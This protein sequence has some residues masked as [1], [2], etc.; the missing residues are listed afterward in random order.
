[1]LVFSHFVVPDVVPGLVPI[2]GMLRKANVA[3]WPKYHGHDNSKLQ[4]SGDMPA[5]HS[6]SLI[7]GAL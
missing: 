6:A 5:I 3:A 1:L 4:K 2:I 7:R